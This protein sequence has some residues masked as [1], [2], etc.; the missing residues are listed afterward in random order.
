MLPVA[1]SILLFSAVYAIFAA[2]VVHALHMYIPNGLIMYGE[3]TM[4]IHV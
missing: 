1:H 3:Q 2:D 4:Q